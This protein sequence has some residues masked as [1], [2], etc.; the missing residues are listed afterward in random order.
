MFESEWC[1]HQKNE[2]GECAI[3]TQQGQLTQD[4]APIVNNGSALGKYVKICI[5]ACSSELQKRCK[6]YI[7]K[8]G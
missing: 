8:S 5:A 2:A 6:L 7:Y 4:E 1:I 3:E